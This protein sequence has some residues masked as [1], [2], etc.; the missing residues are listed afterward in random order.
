[1]TIELLLILGLLVIF[2][3]P[4][5]TD[6]NVGIV[7]FVVSMCL[8]SFALDLSPREILLGFPAQMFVL[9]VGITLL[10]AIAERNGTIDWIVSSLLALARG[11]LFYLPLL[12][13]FTAFIT[14]SLGPGA[15][16]VLFVIGAGLIGRF[17]LNPLLIAAMVIHGTQSGAYSPIA[18]YGIVIHQLAED[19]SIGYDAWSLYAGVVGFH[20]LLGAGAFF[21]LGG[22]RLRGQVFDVGPETPEADRSPTYTRYITLGGFAA[23]LIAVIG[24]GIHLGFAAM[25][26]A[27]VLLLTS[28]KS[29]R[30]EAVSNVAWPIVLVITG[31]LTYVS[32]IQEA[33]AIDWLAGYANSVASPS[34]VGLMLCYLVSVITGVASTIGTIGMLVPL[35]APLITAGDTDGTSL[36]TAMAVSAAVSDVSP[37]STWGALFLASVAS[38]TN[39]E[40]VL[41]LQLVYT[42]VIVTVLPFIAWALFVVAGVVAN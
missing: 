22:N 36:L 18:P 24:F 40:T 2:I 38:V 6:I 31:V 42:A 3:L 35:S 32:M 41:R 13:F 29:V 5:I 16:P 27:F 23:L 4:I 30:S 37:F 11:R 19:L 26:I 12:L 21:L 34:I 10:L 25:T 33:G 28:P 8:G 14:S 7:A 17:G 1:M 15:A 9:I 20:I 39:R